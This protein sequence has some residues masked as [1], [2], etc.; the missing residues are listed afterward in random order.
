MDVDAP[1]SMVQHKIND[2]PKNENVFVFSQKFVGLDN[3]VNATDNVEI[4]KTLNSFSN[5]VK[6]VGFDNTKPVNVPIGI[7]NG[8]ILYLRVAFV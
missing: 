4:T 1:T 6:F 3:Q 5:M 7:G 2:L 8:I